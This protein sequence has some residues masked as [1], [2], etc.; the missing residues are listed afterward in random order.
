MFCLNRNCCCTLHG[1]VRDL[2]GELWKERN[3]VERLENENRRLKKLLNE[4]KQKLVDTAGR[5]DRFNKRYG[6]KTDPET[7]AAAQ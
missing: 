6:K 1:C 4:Q 7:T 3:R 2:K 5:V